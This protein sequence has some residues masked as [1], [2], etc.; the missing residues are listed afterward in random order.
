MEDARE[1]LGKELGMNYLEVY[2][3]GYFVPIVRV[4]LDYKAPIQLGDH[5][6]VQIILEYSKAAKIIHHYNIWNR[7]TDVLAC[8]AYS[9][10]VFIN[11]DTRELELYKPEM[12][13]SWCDQL[14]WKTK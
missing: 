2:N 11:R 3:Q 12:Y 13:A 7:T 10:Q 1:F 4:N 8:A 9:E 14:D 5:V 6:G